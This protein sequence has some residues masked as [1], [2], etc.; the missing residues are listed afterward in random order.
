[1]SEKQRRLARGQQV[2]GDAV[3]NKL[4]EPR[5]TKSS[6]YQKIG[7][8]LRGHRVDSCGGRLPGAWISISSTSYPEC[9]K[10]DKRSVRTAG[11]ISL[12]STIEINKSLVVRSMKAPAH[13]IARADVRL[14]SHAM[15][16]VSMRPQKLEGVGTRTV[17]TDT[18]RPNGP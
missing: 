16:M 3:E 8:P 2:A 4:P 5:I 12:S 7:A 6:G 14:P 13:E 11:S 18:L 10:L 15:A 9:R 17:P 1:M